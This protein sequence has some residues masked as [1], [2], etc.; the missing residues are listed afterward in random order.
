MFPSGD[1]HPIDS[2]DFD[3]ASFGEQQDKL[4]AEKIIQVEA[5]NRKFKIVV[6]FKTDL[7]LPLFGEC[8]KAFIVPLEV[9]Y[10]AIVG[11]GMA[12]FCYPENSRG[13]PT[14][15]KKIFNNSHLPSPDKLL[16]SFDEKE[17]KSVAVAGGKG[18][19]IA[20]LKDIQD[21]KDNN[22]PDY[23]VP[24]GFIVSVSA[25][26]QH[27]KENPEIK[28]RLKELEDIAYEKVDGDIHE[29]C[30]R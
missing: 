30:K 4:P 16:I 25:M 19:S 27:L 15:I 17:A 13:I 18:S 12:I 20:I 9:T 22:V 29:A 5:G 23:F 3:L 14:K 10:N 6:N 7:K 21:S 11:Y 26:D 28:D 8:S 24:Q 2:T 1:C